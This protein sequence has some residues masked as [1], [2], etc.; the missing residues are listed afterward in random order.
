MGKGRL[1][2]INIIGVIIIFALVAGGAYYYYQNTNYVKTD[3]AKVAG[4]MTTIV[5]PAAG[6]LTN[7]NV[8]EGDQLKKGSR[9]GTISGGST[10]MNITASGDGTVV[11]EQANDNQLVQPGQ[12]LAQIIDMSKLYITANIE[13]TS[14]QDITVGDSV[15]ITV[16]G[17]PNTVYEGKMEKIGYAT[18][19]T[20]SL[21]PQQNASGNYTKVTQKVP[22][23]ISIKAPSDKVLP[24]M[25]AEVSIS[26]K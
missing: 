5:A 9:V 12:V 22:V 11:R 1:I 21:M 20:F 16:D 7:W 13:E 6:Q 26:T 14:L 8:Q 18:N 2:F 4:D 24:G 19:S 23:R 17:D 15:D 10:P 25:N 3:E